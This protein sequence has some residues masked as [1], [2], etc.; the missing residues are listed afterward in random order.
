MSR[1]TRT[2]AFSSAVLRVWLARTV[3]R[4]LTQVSGALLVECGAH[5]TL[6]PSA[7]A[8]KRLSLLVGFQR[9]CHAI[10]RELPKQFGATAIVP[11]NDCQPGSSPLSRSYVV[12][13][14]YPR[15][16]DRSMPN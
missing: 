3:S 2:S 13:A 6:V 7:A 11:V 9:R 5:N 1:C 12:H 15:D 14:I 10:R 8:A 4:R 16:I